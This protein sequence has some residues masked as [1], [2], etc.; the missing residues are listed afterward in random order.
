[1]PDDNDSINFTTAGH[2]LGRGILRSASP[3]QS[4]DGLRESGGLDNNDSIGATFSYRQSDGSAFSDVSNRC[5][6]SCILVSIERRGPARTFVMMT[7]NF[8]GSLRVTAISRMNSGLL[9]AFQ[10]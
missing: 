10:L 6:C 5:E 1:M 8:F 4:Q 3:G 7:L 9:Y 2:G